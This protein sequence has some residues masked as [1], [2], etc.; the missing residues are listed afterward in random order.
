MRFVSEVTIENNDGDQM[1]HAKYEFSKPIQLIAELRKGIPSILREVKGVLEEIDLV[2][3][4]ML[5]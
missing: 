1:F 2:Q 4:D 3:E 5:R